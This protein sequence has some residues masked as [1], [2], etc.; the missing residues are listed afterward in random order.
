MSKSHGADD[1][2]VRKRHENSPLNQEPDALE[3][4]TKDENNDEAPSGTSGDKTEHITN[5]NDS[6]KEK[7][8]SEEPKTNGKGKEFYIPKRWIVT[9]LSGLGL[10]LVYSMRTNVGVMVVMIL[11]ERAYEKVGTID[12]MINVSLSRYIYVTF[13]L[14]IFFLCS[15]IFSF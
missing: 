2:V 9:F 4:T 7:Q 5:D 1:T 6:N 8:N 14:K 10:L 3:Q 12:A 15:F 13:H 11:D